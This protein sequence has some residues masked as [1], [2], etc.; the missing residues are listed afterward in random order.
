MSGHRYDDHH[1]NIAGGGVRA[2]VFGASDG[3]VS[4]VLLI[5]GLAAADASAGVVQTAGLAGL[6]AGAISMASG[7]YVSVRAQN[8]LVEREIE[9][10]KKALA[11]DP[12]EEAEEL[13]ELYVERGM[14]L[15]Q[16]REMANLLMENPEVALEVHVREELGVSPDELASPFSTAAWSFFSFSIGALIPVLPWLVSSGNAAVIG[17]LALAIAAAATIGV[18]IALITGRSIIKNI[19]RHVGI[20]CMAAAAIYC[21]GSLI[22]GVVDM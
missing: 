18:V 19:F 2:A 6:L 22:A 15:K 21:I 1:R 14:A 8:D 7:E 9:K 13:A 12:E 10:E 4:N 5:I 17:S 16:A 3:L 20:A 11:E